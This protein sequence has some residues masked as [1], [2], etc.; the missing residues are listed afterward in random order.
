MFRSSLRVTSALKNTKVRAQILQKWQECLAVTQ[1]RNVSEESKS[2]GLNLFRGQGQAEQVFPFPEVLNEEQK[3][4]LQMFADQTAKFFEEQNDASKNDLLEKVDDDTMEGLKALGAFG[5]QVPTDLDG[6]GLTN[7][8][9]ARLVEIV[10]AHDLGVGIVL[11]AHQSI[12]FKGIILFGTPE[13]KSKYLPK[14]AVGENIAAFCLTEPASGSDASSIKT[15]AVLS[16]DGKHYILNGSKIWISN[17]GL[18]EIF[19][20]FAQTPVKDAKTGETKDKVTA[21]I[22]ERS[23]GGVTNGPPEK[24]MGIKCSNTA[25]VYFED[26]KIPVENVLGGEGG[27]FKVAM[28]ILNNGRFGMVAA[29][30]GTMKYCIQKAV[31][32]AA[33]RVQFGS[34][35]HSFGAIQEKLSQMAIKHYVAESMAYMISANMDQGFKDFQIEAAIG[36]IYA[37]EGAWF[38]A[39]E[40]IQILGGMGFMRDCGIERVMRDL[41][42]FRIFEGTNDILR[43]FIAL[44]GMQ[45]AGA[46]LKEVQ[47]AMKNPM[48]NIG[49][50]ASFASK[51]AV[52]KMGGSTG[53]VSLHTHP[54]VHSDLSTA[55]KEAS[56]SIEDFGGT[57]EQLLIKYGKKIMNEQMVLNRV[58]EAAIDI[59]GMVSVLSRASRSLNNQYSSAASESAMC[60]VFC[61]QAAVRVDT[62]L[63]LAL[64][65]KDKKIFQQMSTISEDV[66]KHG[67]TVQEH[68]LGF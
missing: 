65:D 21:F 58:S 55:A 47:K 28:N 41:R 59:Y 27:G 7:T 3:E 66:I 61:S 45:Y 42:I 2:F 39:D 43:L 49:T 40:A 16:D 26:V 12:G 6:L 8:Q 17:G 1:T 34:H 13:Q 38:C 62:N 32:H 31:D 14:L 18:A 68:P 37:S 4:N 5:L 11:G 9:Y 30:S 24:K 15:R 56:K 54:S 25:E 48:A 57:V 23:F 53:N 46:H 35:I 50:V 33:T 29:L 20:V 19:T 52:R 64:S 36:K 63:K 22:V 10:G 67:G 60:Q 51:M 44:T